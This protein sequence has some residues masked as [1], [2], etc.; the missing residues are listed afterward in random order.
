[1]SNPS[2]GARLG[3]GEP[4]QSMLNDFCAAH[5]NAPERDMIRAALDFFIQNRLDAEPEVK[6]RFEEARRKRLGLSDSVVRI[7][8][9]NE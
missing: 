5:Y 3:L 2:K 9:K 8:P 1:M 6:K 4:W 7:V